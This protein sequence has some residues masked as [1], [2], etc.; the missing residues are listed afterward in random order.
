MTDAPR[1]AP[2][3]RL[4]AEALVLA[5]A[6]HP[7]HVL[8]HQWVHS[9][10][11]N[12]GCEGVEPNGQRWRGQCSVPVYECDACGDLDYGDNDEARE[13]RARCLEDAD[14]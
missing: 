1:P 9:G 3:D 13:R 12:C 7:C 8:G 14:G 2:L 6:A 11:A 4:I 5:G 10:G